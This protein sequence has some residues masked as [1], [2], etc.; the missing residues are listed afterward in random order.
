MYELQEKNKQSQWHDYLQASRLFLQ[1]DYKQ[2]YSILQTFY[3][4]NP[5]D[6]PTLH[7]LRQCESKM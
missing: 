7:L 4:Q 6:G 2:A 1:Q 3:Q 5:Q